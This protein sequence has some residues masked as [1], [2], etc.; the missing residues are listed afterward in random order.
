MHLITYGDLKFNNAK[1]RLVK[2]AY[3]TNWFDTITSYGPE[4][5]DKEFYQDLIIF[6]TFEHL[7]CQHIY[8]YAINTSFLMYPFN[9]EN[10]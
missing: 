5:L 2:E 1:K 10:L 8:K 3:N 7:K 4:D 6:Y 9:V